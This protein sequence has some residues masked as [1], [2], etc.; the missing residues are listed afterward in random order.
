MPTIKQ[1]KAIDFSKVKGHYKGK[2]WMALEDKEKACKGKIERFKAATSEE[3]TEVKR[4]ILLM[5]GKEVIKNDKGMWGCDFNTKDG[6]HCATFTY[7]NGM[8][9]IM[10]PFKVRKRSDGKLTSRLRIGG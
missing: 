4:G 5:G 8:R 1:C 3:W 10:K 2:E 9:K 6:K 7:I